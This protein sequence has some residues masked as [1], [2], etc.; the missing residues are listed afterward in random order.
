MLND[1]F[2]QEDNYE[3]IKTDI[4]KL[5]TDI[6]NLLQ[7]INTKYTNILNIIN[8]QTREY[9]ILH[10]GTKN[11]F[12][13]KKQ[14]KYEQRQQFNN[15]SINECNKNKEIVIQEERQLDEIN[16]LEAEIQIGEAEATAKKKK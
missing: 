15:K 16:L 7:N 8:T 9:E 4:S 5:F 13:T 3:T 2:I 14:E 1:K 11:E 6:I 12:L 10:N